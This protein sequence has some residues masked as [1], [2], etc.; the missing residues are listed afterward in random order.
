[1]DGIAKYRFLL[2]SENPDRLKDFYK[3]ILELPLEF[4]LDLP[5]DYGYMFKLSDDFKL[6]IGQHSEVTGKS[7]EPYRHIL[8]LYVTDVHAWFDRVKSHPEVQIICEPCLTPTSTEDKPRY[9]ATFLDPEGN[10][11]QFMTPG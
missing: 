7:S 3:D 5:N 6:W 10:C 2:F 1:M 9:V 11:L 4:S 8:N